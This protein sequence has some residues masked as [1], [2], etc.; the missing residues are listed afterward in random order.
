MITRTKSPK[1]GIAPRSRPKKLPAQHQDSQPGKE[2]KMTPQPEYIR[3]SY[4]GSAKL[5]GKVAIV[6]GGDSG[7]G[8]AVSVH[9]AREGANVVIVYLNEDR[10]AKETRTLVEAEGQRCLL[11]SGDLGKAAFCRK[12]VDKTMKKFGRIDVLVNNAAEQHFEEDFEKI[13]DET[14]ERT[15]RTNIFSMFYLTKAALA[16][17]KKRRGHHQ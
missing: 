15:F 7:I 17:M 8:R 2:Y 14:M 12:V 6:T 5:Q 11:L 9:F 4:L 13:K 16:H 1:R 3:P 10:D